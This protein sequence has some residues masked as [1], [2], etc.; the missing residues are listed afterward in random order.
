VLIVVFALAAALLL[1]SPSLLGVP[2][3]LFP[4]MKV[5]DIL[6]ILTPL[7]LM[8]LYWLLYRARRGERPSRIENLAFVLLATFW[9]E[10]QGMHL[11][12]NSIYHWLDGAKEGDAF[13]LTFFFD[14]LLSHYLWHIGVVGLSLLLMAGKPA[15]PS[16][17]EP[18]QWGSLIL[19]GAIHGFTLFLMFVEGRTVEFG[20]LSAIVITL[21]GL[22]AGPR[23][24]AAHPVSA[25]FWIAYLVTTLFMAGWGIYWGGFPEFSEIGII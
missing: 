19:A 23:R 3:P 17:G 15:T 4:L 11:S 13:K 21:Y 9:V 7:V 18:V 22:A 6:D 24:L 14:E 20:L 12:A 16:A 8:P 2:F 25:F 10:G 5:G 1:I